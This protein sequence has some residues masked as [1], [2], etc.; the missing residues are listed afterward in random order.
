MYTISDVDQPSNFLTSN[1]LTQLYS[2]MRHILVL[3]LAVASCAVTACQGEPDTIIT[4]NGFRF[5]NHTN[6]GG[7]KPKPTDWV[8]VTTYA[9]IK[10]SLMLDSN[11]DFGG[12][13]ES[14]LAFEDKLYGKVPAM[15][16]AIMLMGLGDSA[17]VYEPLDSF[18]LTYVPEGLKDAK[19]V[20]YT[21][22]LLKITTKEEKEKAGPQGNELT[23]L[24][25][26]Q[27]KTQAVIQDYMAGKLAG[28]LK[29]TPTGVKILIEEA[30]NGSQ[31]G[32]GEVVQ[33]HYWGSLTSGQM[34]DNSYERGQPI[35]FTTASGEMIKGFEDGI[36]QLKHGAKAFIFIPPSQ[37]YGDNSK[38]PIPPN[39]ELVFYLEVL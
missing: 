29:T 13:Q 24:A 35:S 10:D 27:T 32:A 39:S 37:G 36:M 3:I 2:I 30:G 14:E 31:V 28:K 16:D 23:A 6:K 25:G 11:R 22:V 7:Q 4:K 9:H 26:Y 20:A 8:L 33:A 19:E 21:I 17:T 12:P 18:A 34:F 5:I 1:L 38:G 15:Y